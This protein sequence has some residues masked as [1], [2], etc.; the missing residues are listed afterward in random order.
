MK[1][2][3]II[4]CCIITVLC[5]A[6]SNTDVLLQSDNGMWI[7][8]DNLAIGE[9]FNKAKY[10]EVNIAWSTG[11]SFSNVSTHTGVRNLQMQLAKK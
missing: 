6:Q 11:G 9:S 4:I 5:K 7:A 10:D 1:Y 8:L 2:F 3:G